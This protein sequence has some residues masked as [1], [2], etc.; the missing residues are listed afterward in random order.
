MW[1]T[2]QTNE[3]DEDTVDKHSTRE[4]NDAIRTCEGYNSIQKWSRK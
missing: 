4:K 3:T 1:Y 2:A